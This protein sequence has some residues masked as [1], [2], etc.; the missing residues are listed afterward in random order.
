MQRSAYIPALT[1]VRAVAAMMVLLG[2]AAPLMLFNDM[3]LM[4]DWYYPL[5][6]NGMSVFF[7]LSGFLMWTHYAPKF[8]A[9][10]AMHAAGEFAVARF[11]RIYPLYLLVL[12]LAFMRQAPE[13]VAAHPENL[14]F[15]ALLQAWIPEMHGK[16][17]LLTVE[18]EHTWSISAEMFCYAIFPLLAIVTKN[19]RASVFVGMI[20]VSVIS[21]SL[22]IYVQNHHFETARLFLAPHL[23]PEDANWWIFYYSPILRIFEFAIGCYF[24][25]LAET[26]TPARNGWIFALAGFIA[27]L[28]VHSNMASPRHF[29]LIA[30][31]F[32]R[33]GPSAFTGY[34]LYHVASRETQLSR[35]LSGRLITMIGEC[36]YSIYLIHPFILKIFHQTVVNRTTFYL[37]AW[38][39]VEMSIV[40]IITTASAWGLYQV[41]EIPSRKAIRRIGA[42]RPA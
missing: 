18:A 25:A 23:S 36:S 19:Y 14:Y 27:V 34:L 17:F 2:H 9:D 33:A 10:G 15:L 13:D 4:Q 26:R 40:V 16:L 21:I 28:I 42:T 3:P 30:Y 5:P 32:V 35:L 41:V 7:A 8:R 39:A 1:G 29:G 37:L 24:A 12:L 20:C 22:A 38:Y 11:A 31:M 6:A